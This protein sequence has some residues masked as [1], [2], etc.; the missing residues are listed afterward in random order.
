[1]LFVLQFEGPEGGQAFLTHGTPEEGKG[2][3]AESIGFE[4]VGLGEVDRVDLL[5]LGELGDLNCVE[6]LQRN[7]SEI[8]VRDHHVTASADFVAPDELMLL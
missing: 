4:E 2:L 3:R 1:M 8:V 7:R 5:H 6:A